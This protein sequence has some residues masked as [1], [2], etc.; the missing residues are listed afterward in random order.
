MIRCS[1]ST[2]GPAESQEMDG[3]EIDEGRGS[4]CVCV[5]SFKRMT[6]V[7][8]GVHSHSSARLDRSLAPAEKSM[9]KG[10][11]SLQASTY[12]LLVF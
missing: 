8:S 3:I 7:T 10:R 9:M 11:W 6:S 12:P 1:D 4:V 5:Q 2:I